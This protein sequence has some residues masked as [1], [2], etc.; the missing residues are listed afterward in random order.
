MQIGAAGLGGALLPAGIGVLISRFGVETLGPS[1]VVLSL[2]LLGLHL[3]SARRGRA[4]A[5]RL[6][7]V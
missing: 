7:E 5:G 1:L 2:L 6:S 4:T 3:G